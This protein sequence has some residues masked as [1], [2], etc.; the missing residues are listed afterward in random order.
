MTTQSQ[1]H[2]KEEFD[3]QYAALKASF[4]N[5]KPELEVTVRDPD[6]D[7][8]GFIVVWNTK[9]SHDGPLHGCGKGGTRIKDGLTIDEIKRLSC[10]MAEKNAAAGLPLGGAKSGLNADPTASDYEIKYRRFVKLCEPYLRENG[11]IFGGFGY[12]IGGIPPKNAIWACDELGTLGSFTGKPVDMGGTDYDKEGIAG[13]GVAVAGHALLSKNDINSEGASFAVQGLGAM[14]AAVVRYFSEYGGKLKAIG[15]PRFGGSWQFAEPATQEIITAM[16]NQDTDTVKTLLE[17]E[18]TLISD[19]PQDVLYE[20]VHILFPCAIEDVLT[21]DNANKVKAKFISE[22]ANNPTTDEAHQ[23]LFDN[24]ALV[25]PD[26]IANPG[27]IIAAFVELSSSVSAEENAKTRAKVTEAKDM[28]RTKVAEN[29]GELLTL[30]K[31]LG[32]RPDLAGDFMAWR[33]IIHGLPQSKQMR[34]A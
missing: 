5:M 14:G 26:I 21:K 3:Q 13:L 18:A 20:D 4:Q 31:T 2:N 15:D 28:T 34:A 11:G 6:M 12:D 22:G 23:I 24:G 9:I 8:E 1:P 29:V 33:N 19:S 7:V 30:V 17:K 27:G 32:V 25:V 16:T 10:S